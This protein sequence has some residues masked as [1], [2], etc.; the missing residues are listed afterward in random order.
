MPFG[1]QSTEEYNKWKLSNRPNILEVLQ[2]F[3]SAEV[4]T[5]FLLAQLPLLKPRYYSVS[6]SCD[7]TARE[8]HLTV[9]VVNYRTRGNE[10]FFSYL[11]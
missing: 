8:I 2:E 5:A 10:L 4:S 3:P 11:S 7:M 1:F 9:A 6:S